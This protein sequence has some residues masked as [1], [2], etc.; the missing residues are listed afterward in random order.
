MEK[1]RIYYPTVDS[2]IA[3]TRRWCRAFEQM[4]V[5]ARANSLGCAVTADP[6]GPL[7]IHF[8]PAGLTGFAG[9]NLPWELP[10]FPS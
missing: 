10:G 2:R 9:R 4:A 8:N 3:S 6:Q 7:S 1:A 5:E